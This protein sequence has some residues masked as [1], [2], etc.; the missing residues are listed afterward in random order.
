MV[1]WKRSSRPSKKWSAT[2]GNDTCSASGFSHRRRAAHRA[3]LCPPP[4]FAG[5]GAP[6][7][8]GAEP[9]PPEAVNGEAIVSLRNATGL[10]TGLS[11][12]SRDPILAPVVAVAL[13]ACLIE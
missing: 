1:T 3:R 10:P 5:A 12:H 8:G 9:V 13:G 6:G 2:F 4:P 7:P 11:D